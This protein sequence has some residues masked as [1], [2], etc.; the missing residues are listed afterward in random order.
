MWLL[1]LVSPSGAFQ[2]LSTVEET[3]PEG[4]VSG[5]VEQDHEVTGVAEPHDPGLAP[6]AAKFPIK[7]E[8]DSE[9]DWA[10]LREASRS[11]V[12]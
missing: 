1:I 9:V 11:V 12:N 3:T 8:P 4:N 6:E 10:P 5:V 7:V 2:V